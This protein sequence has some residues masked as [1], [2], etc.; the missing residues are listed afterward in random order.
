MN[1]IEIIRQVLDRCNMRL[2][3]L[4]NNDNSF[5]LE[6]YQALDKIVKRESSL[7]GQPQ[8]QIAG[9]GIS[10]PHSMQPGTYHIQI[11]RP[12]KDEKTVPDEESS[13]REELDRLLRQI[14]NL[15]DTLI[16]EG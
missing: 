6:A 7:L 13:P 15:F 8:S 1:D 16:R 5:I 10:F 2:T 11:P 9:L 4:G 12:S 14:I 3:A